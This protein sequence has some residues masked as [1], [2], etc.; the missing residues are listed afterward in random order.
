LEKKR[1]KQKKNTQKQ[2]KNR[3]HNCLQDVLKDFSNSLN[4]C[5]IG[6]NF[7][8]DDCHFEQYHKIENKKEKRFGFLLFI[9]L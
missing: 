3:H 9:Y 1:K 6:Q 7:L 8:M 4:I 2:L 5:Q